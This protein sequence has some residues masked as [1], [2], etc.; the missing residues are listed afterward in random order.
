MKKNN[1]TKSTIADVIAPMVAITI[2]LDTI[3]GDLLHKKFNMSLADFKVLRVIYILGLCTQL[4]IARFNHVT[5]AAISKR[6]KSMSKDSLIKKQI[7][8]KDKRKFV[9]SLSSKGNI[10]MKK[11][12]TVVIRN[13]E[14]ILSDFSKANRKLTMTLLVEILESVIKHSPN[15][16]TLLQS[17]HPVLDRLNT[18]I[19]NSELS[20]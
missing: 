12:Q 8:K 2:E 3:I 7:S 9:V 5:E 14:L 4:D 6:I 16:D 15:K 18:G 19:I 17:K 13:T 10:L 11:I 1:P 20:T